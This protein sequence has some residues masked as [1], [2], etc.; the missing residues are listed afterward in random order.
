MNHEIYPHWQ[1]RILK[2]EASVTCWSYVLCGQG[3]LRRL[4]FFTDI[5]WRNFQTWAQQRHAKLTKLLSSELEWWASSAMVVSLRHG[6]CNTHNYSLDR[7]F[8]FR[9][10]RVNKKVLVGGNWSKNLTSSAYCT[11]GFE[12][13]WL[14]GPILE[15]SIQGKHWFFGLSGCVPATTSF[16]KNVFWLP[17]SHSVLQYSNSLVY[18][19]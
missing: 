18:R 8:L 12:T 11:S 2:K 16:E 1:R 17:R 3:S 7:R 10:W 13:N 4:H 5:V 19:S 14:P 15:V 9:F 6:L